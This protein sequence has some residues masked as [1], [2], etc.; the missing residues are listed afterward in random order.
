MLVIKPFLY[1]WVYGALTMPPSG[2]WDLSAMMLALS[3][4][5]SGWGYV[6][7]GLLRVVVFPSCLGSRLYLIYM[8]PSTD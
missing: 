7:L 6:L 5:C 3:W 1:M 8:H 2:W 4:V